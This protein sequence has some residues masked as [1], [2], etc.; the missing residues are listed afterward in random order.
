MRKNISRVLMLAMLTLFFDTSGII[1]FTKQSYADVGFEENDTSIYISIFNTISKPDA[2]YIAQRAT[3][4][5]YKV[6]VVT[7]NSVGGNVDAAMR[8]GPGCLNRDSASIS[9]VSAGVRLPCGGAA[10]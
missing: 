2:N 10:A 9:G 1:F 7:L 4:L 8:G 3:N 5:E 6:T